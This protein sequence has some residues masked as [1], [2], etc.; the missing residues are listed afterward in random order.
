MHLFSNMLGIFVFDE[1]IEV[2]DEILFEKMAGVDAIEPKPENVLFFA[3]HDLFDK[4]R[5]VNNKA[6]MGAIEFDA[7]SA[8]VT[9]PK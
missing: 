2:V 1:K 6:D 3:N 4:V 5:V 9:M 8:T 7:A